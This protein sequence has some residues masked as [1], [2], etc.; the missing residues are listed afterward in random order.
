EEVRYLLDRGA[1]PDWIA[2]NGYSV[3]EHAI[4]RYW[5]GD[6]VDV[7]A[8]RTK[9]RKAFWISAG[10]GDVDGVRRFLDRDG[11]PTPATRLARPD[12]DSLGSLGLPSVPEA[13]DI[14]VLTEAFMVA[15]LNRRTAVLEYLISRGYPINT[16]EWDMPF[17]VMAVGNGV[18]DVVECLI[19]CGADLDLQGAYNGSARE[20]ARDMLENSPSGKDQRR[21]A[22]LCGLDPD[23]VLAELDARP[24]PTPNMDRRL[25]EALDLASDD[26]RRQGAPAVSAENLLFGL[27]RQ[28]QALTLFTRVSGMD[29][30]R[31]RADMTSRVRPVQDSTNG[32][33]LTLNSDAQALVDHAIAI[34]T[35]RRRQTVRGDHLLGALLRQENGIAADLL[36][37]YGSSAEKLL[38]EMERSL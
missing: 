22:E 12:F 14:D 37:R 30:E 11:K 38:K 10:L 6:A 19:H 18:T 17:L 4:F 34:A 8:A 25:L 27:L 32:P 35:R 21:I 31:F 9:P 13:E 5:N 3:L 24:L 23:A 20:M 2:P 15:F 36:S 33:P 28:G 26:A 1:D 29:F 16:L 7:L